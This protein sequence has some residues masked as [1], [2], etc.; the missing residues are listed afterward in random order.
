[1][2]E[3]LQFFFFLFF[4]VCPN[5]TLTEPSGAISSPFYPRL[6]PDNQACRWHLTAPAGEHIRLF[7]ESINIQQCG[8]QGECTCDYVEIQNGL[9]AAGASSGRICGVLVGDGTY[10]SIGESLTVLFVSDASASKSFD[11]FR[12]TFTHVN[13]TPCK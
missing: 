6:Y 13:S 7:F 2:E 9:T 12:A 4:S 8:A 11:G 1:M 3:L 5:I 10:Y